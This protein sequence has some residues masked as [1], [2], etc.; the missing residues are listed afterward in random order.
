[1]RGEAHQERGYS[2]ELM[3]RVVRVR[4]RTWIGTEIGLKRIFGGVQDPTATHATGDVLG[5]FP[6]D[7]GGQTT[8]QVIAN[9]MNG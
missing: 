2:S 5:N 8:L 6:F 3:L 4:K 9:Q 7:R 1:M